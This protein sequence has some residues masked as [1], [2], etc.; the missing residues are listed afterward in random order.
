MS[1]IDHPATAHDD[2]VT[3]APPPVAIVEPAPY[4]QG[5]PA[6]LGLPIFVAGSTA[7]GLALVGYVSPAG[8]AAALPVILAATGVGLLVSAIWAMSLGQTLVAAVFGLF[9]GFWWSYGV[10][11]LG[12]NHDWFRIPLDDVTHTIA[13]FQITWAGVFTLLALAT[14]RLPVAYTAVVGLVVLALVL[15][16]I[17]TLDTNADLIKAAGYVTFAFA[18]LGAY[19]FLSSASV[20]TGGKPYPVGPPLVR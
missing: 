1:T 13:L 14:V 12:L 20:A 9:S 19:L 4:R 11:V 8:A 6:I 18:A 7:L 3:D 2:A 17:G 15:L 5:D 10:L 16:A